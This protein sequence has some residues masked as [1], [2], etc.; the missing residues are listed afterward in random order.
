MSIAICAAWLAKLTWPFVTDVT[1]SAPPINMHSHAQPMIA[2]MA[3]W[4]NSMSLCDW[5]LPATLF[6]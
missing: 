1:R 2:L 5:L 6:L 3:H 4:G